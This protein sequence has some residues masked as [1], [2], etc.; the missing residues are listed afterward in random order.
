MNHPVA[1]SAVVFAGSGGIGAAISEELAVTHEVVVGYHHNH[2]RAETQVDRI[3]AKSGTAIACGADATT[4]D[5]VNESLSAAEGLGPLPTVVHCVGAGDYPRVT[6]LDENAIDCAYHTHL[7]SA[8]LTLSAAALRV[9]DHGRIIM[10]SRDA[11]YP[12]P[13][14]PAAYVAMKAGLQGAPRG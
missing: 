8:L 2:R 3:S 1:D 13:A 14:R 11:A 4:A 9:V 5:A 12:A 7:R 10:V 6:D